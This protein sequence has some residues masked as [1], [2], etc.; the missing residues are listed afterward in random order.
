DRRPAQ[1]AGYEPDFRGS[2]SHPPLRSQAKCEQDGRGQDD[3]ADAV[4]RGQAAAE[5][6]T[7]LMPQRRPIL[8]IL[9]IGLLLALF[10]A[11]IGSIVGESQT[12]DEGVHLA[13]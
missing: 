3:P 12:A 10:I 1:A 11:Q 8:T 5:I 6:R 9:T 4:T 13:A 2:P 7:A